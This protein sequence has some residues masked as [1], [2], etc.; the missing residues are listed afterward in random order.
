MIAVIKTGGKQYKVEP[1]DKIKIEK[2]AGEAGKEIIFKEI[3]L[4]EKSKKVE[5]G[6]PFVKGA[7]VSSKILSQGKAEKVIAF[8]YGPKT[9]RKTKKGFRQPFTEVEIIKIESGK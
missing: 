8:K 1:G 4:V 3:L 5:I 7:E 9:R 6:S 2:I